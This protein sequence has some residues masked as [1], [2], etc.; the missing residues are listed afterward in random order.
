M[1]S[2]WPGSSEPASIVNRTGPS[3]TAM[4]PRGGPPPAG[5]GRGPA[6][7]RAGDPRGAPAREHAAPPPAETS[8]RRR[9]RRERPRALGP[10]GLDLPPELREQPLPPPSPRPLAR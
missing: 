1:T 3:L 8:R 10:G 7:E 6:P 9:R 4:L 5:A 2:V